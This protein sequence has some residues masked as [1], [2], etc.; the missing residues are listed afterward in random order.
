MRCVLL[1]LILLAGCGS[2]SEG[3]TTPA[4]ADS[5]TSDSGF[6]PAADPDSAIGDDTGSSSGD[7]G[8]NPSDGGTPTEGGTDT[9]AA[10]DAGPSGP[11]T[12]AELLALTTKCTVASKA[13]Y[14]TDDGAADTV[15]V[16]SLP[17]AFFWKA[18][19][20]VDCDGKMSTVCNKSTD[21][22]YQNMTAMTDSK[23]GALDAATLPYV[24]IPTATT[25]R[26]S[27]KTAGISGGAVVAVIYGGKVVY[28][29]FGDTG[30]S[31]IIGEASYAMAK[32]LGI[33][34]D[35]ST[36]GADSG[37]TYIVFTGKGAVPAV[38]E[39]HA[40][41]TK[42]GESLAAKLVGK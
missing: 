5:D 4:E 17:G 26:W 14:A 38:L 20:D 27:Y 32:A 1:G 8:T 9:G 6:S 16:C 13:K 40:A 23:G 15:D 21:P 30:P 10:T 11:P 25:T 19:L 28:G 31:N 7:S 39:D 12:A 29:V 36:G 22:A 3:S 18:D 35:P 33:D 42:L 34:P 24:V 37:V 2:S 41:A